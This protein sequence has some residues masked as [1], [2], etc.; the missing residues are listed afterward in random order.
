M[1]I[2]RFTGGVCKSLEE[3]LC[4]FALGHS[5]PFTPNYQYR[6]G[7]RTGVIQK[8]AIT[9]LN[10]VRLGGRW[11]RVHM[12]GF[13]LSSRRLYLSNQPTSALGAPV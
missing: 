3:P 12:K 4:I 6:H 10:H 8:L 13:S 7:D 1:R 5:V 11:E 2:S 9:R